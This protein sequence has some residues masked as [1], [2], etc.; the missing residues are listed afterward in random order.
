MKLLLDKLGISVDHLKCLDEVFIENNE[1][2]QRINEILN[3]DEFI[4]VYQ[5]FARQ[6]YAG[7]KTRGNSL[8]KLNRQMILGDVIEYIFSG[9]AYY[10]AAKSDDN[11]KDFYKLIFY[12]VN[13]MLLYDTITVNSN[14]RR[15]YIE[16]LE[17]N[18]PLDILYEKP[19]DE[20]L[21]N[22]LKESNIKFGKRTGKGL[23]L[24]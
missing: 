6:L 15:L 22:E 20:Q 24:L 16:K 11:L 14:L 9:Q 21:A 10:H 1:E 7:G 23:I 12:S 2:Y 18:I 3:S 17:E 19:G 5:D 8:L 4:S 13:Q